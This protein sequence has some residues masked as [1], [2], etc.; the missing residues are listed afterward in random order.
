[1]TADLGSL[2]IWHFDSLDK[3]V[4]AYQWDTEPALVPHRLASSAWPE[5][6]ARLP[7]GQVMYYCADVY[8]QASPDVF[9]RVD[10]LYQT[11]LDAAC[12]WLCDQQPPDW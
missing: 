10:A 9:A 11:G 3:V 7:T 2:N 4:D 1:M 6:A 5:L 8:R 12:S